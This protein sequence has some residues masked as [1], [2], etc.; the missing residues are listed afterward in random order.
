MGLLSKMSVQLQLKNKA[1]QHQKWLQIGGR[2]HHIVGTLDGK[3]V[4]MQH[5]PTITSHC[6]TCY[7]LLFICD[8]GF[9]GFMW[10]DV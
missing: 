2:V 8:A 10:T 1:A 3:H 7:I 9:H 4:T 5:P 6:N